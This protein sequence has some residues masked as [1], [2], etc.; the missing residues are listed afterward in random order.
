MKK[1]Y[2]QGSYGFDKQFL[3]SKLDVVELSNE[4]S[5]VIVVP[6]YQGR[7]MTSTCRGNEGNSYGWINY[8]LIKSGEVLEHMNG[9]GGEERFW[10]GPEGGQFSIFF[11]KGVSFD[12]E[13][14][15]TPKEIDTEA[16]KLVSNTDK[17]A[18]FEQD[19]NLENYS[20]TKF[21]LKVNRIIN[22]LSTESITKNLNIDVSELDEVAYET[23][24]KLT[25]TGQDSWDENSGMLSIWLLGMLNP[26]PEVTV[27]IPV[28]QGSVEELG[29]EVNDNYF[30]KISPD[31][32]KTENNI[33]FFKADG[34]SRGKIGI[35]PKR[36]KPILGSYDAKNNILTIVEVILP[37]NESKYVNSA[38]ELQ[39]DPFSGDAINSYNDGP[40][41]DGS[42]MGPFYEIESSSPALALK[43]G[44]S[45]THIQRTYHFEGNV[46]KL[47]K[48]AQKLLGV[49]I[50][51]IN[52]QF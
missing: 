44:G 17:S 6:K 3:A 13:N 38:W 19:M 35:S 18:S 32:L 5:K 27:V 8:E 21:S 12:F 1:E 22:L 51:E 15:F 47:D 10:L 11:K 49:S 42:Q 31:R 2:K 40:L 16:F 33:V 43:P 25:N 50:S 37:K 52:K 24:N 4:K 36:A 14:W 29:A 48:I 30:G 20:G 39:D 7:V 41:E 28:K 9:F 45:Y 26:S 34:N 23:I 46:E